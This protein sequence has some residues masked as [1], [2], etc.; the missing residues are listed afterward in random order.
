MVGSR[1]RLQVVGILH[2]RYTQDFQPRYY[3]VTKAKTFL[4]PRAPF[5]FYFVFTFSVPEVPNSEGN[6]IVTIAVGGARGDI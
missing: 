6:P 2:V 4:Q 1:Y 5:F 3:V